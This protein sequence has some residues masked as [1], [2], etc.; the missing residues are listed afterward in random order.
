MCNEHTKSNNKT[1]HESFLENYILSNSLQSNVSLIKEI[2]N[3]DDTLVVRYFENQKNNSV[4][5]CIIFLQE[6]IDNE[7]INTN[8]IKPIIESTYL[9]EEHSNIENILN[10]IIF[11]NNVNK[12][13][14]V[15]KIIESILNGNTVLFLGS[16]SEALIVSTIG[17]KSREIKEPEGEK[18]IRGPREG[19]TES[20][21][22]NISMVRRKL[23]TPDLKF[24]FRVL[25][26]RTQTKICL[27]YIDGI[28][29]NKILDE[30]N[31]RLNSIDI[32]GTLASGYIQELIN[33][34]PFSPFKTIGNTE[35]PDIVAAKLLEGRI[36]I[37]VDATPI[38]LTVP[39][40]FIELFQ[41]NEDYY[42]NFY[43]SSIS[44][45]LRIL[46]FIITISLPSLFIALTTFHIEAI[47]TPLAISISAARQDVPFPTVVEALGLLLTFEILRETGVRMPNQIGQA[48]SIVGA[49]VLGQAAVDA[50]FVSAP[51][52]IVIALTGITGLAIPK[53]KGASILLRIILLIFSSILGLYGF[54][55]GIIGL[56]IH[57]FK[58]RSFGVPYMLSLMTL[59]PQDLKDTAIRAP[60]F[61]MKYRPKFIAANNLIRKS[62][63]G[64]K[65]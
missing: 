55:F 31:K 47:P 60:W 13:N 64:S 46:S 59:K 28:V 29:N 51:M 26:T 41:A 45:L 34:E 50:R 33:D 11:S 61:Y 10:H 4:K 49:L 63:G 56:M 2:F 43:F 18:T 21:M 15:N 25:G 42:I 48:F 52:I 14:D 7:T 40:I 19:F 44:R 35:R 54:I 22:V 24:K 37:M 27:C 12:T 3:D 9:N 23:L 20:L 57:L 38:V 30:L 39:H 36:A 53:V 16:E 17:W 5:C 65:N 1:S 32:D 6:M 8:I 62:S 58:M